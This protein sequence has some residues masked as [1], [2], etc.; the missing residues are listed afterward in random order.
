MRFYKMSGSGNDFIMLDGR[1]TTPG[2]WPAPRIVEVCH[3]RN[4]VGADGLV[5]LT[6]G[7][8]G[9]VRMD[10][11]NSDGSEAAMCG[12]AAL[13]STCLATYL[14]M[15]Q[16]AGM[17]LQTGAGSF[18]TRTAPEPWSAELNLPDFPLPVEVPI[19]CQQGERGIWAG[20]VGVPHLTILVDDIEAVDINGRGRELRFHPAAGPAGANANFIAGPR[21]QAEDRAWE[22]RTF[23]RGVEGETLACGTGTVASAVALAAHGRIQLPA[24]IRSRSGKPLR[25]AATL[26]G[27]WARDVWLRGEGRLVFEGHLA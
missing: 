2:D 9:V 11:Y 26:E 16:A 1:E 17:T 20:T 22:L 27:G 14:H 5:I 6:P 10:F 25:V 19:A 8:P 4:G 15:A 13:C 23:E 7:V 12:N 3:R 18:P 24:V 21:N